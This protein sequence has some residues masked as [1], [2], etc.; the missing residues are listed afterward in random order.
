MIIEQ[1][2]KGH[3]A[4]LSR[5]LVGFDP[6][7][8]SN[9]TAASWKGGLSLFKLESVTWLTLANTR[10]W[11]KQSVTWLTLGVGQNM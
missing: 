3:I 4:K 7:L 8:G 1:M 10:C 2:P 9:P 6:F 11:Q 5:R